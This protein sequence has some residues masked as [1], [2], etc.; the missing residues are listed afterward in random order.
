MPPYK[1]L[2]TFTYDKHETGLS[3]LESKYIFDGEDE[4]KLLWSNKQVDPSISAFI[5]QRLKVIVSNSDYPTLIQ[6]IKELDIHIEG[7]KVE[8]L[9]LEGDPTAYADRLTKL[10]DIGYRI[11]GNPDYYKPTII[12]TLCN[13]RGTW[14]FGSMTKDKFDWYKHGKKP[15]S[16]SNSIS[17]NIAKALVNIATGSAR[18]KTILDACCGVGTIMLEAC[19][20]GYDIEGC[21]INWKI[22]RNARVN[23]TH[24]GYETVVY[25]SD[26]KDIDKRYDAAIIDLPYNLLSQATDETTAHIIAS[27][28]RIAQR[29]VIVSIVDITEIIQNAG[30]RLL[31]TCGVGKRGKTGFERRVW[32]CESADFRAW[33]NGTGT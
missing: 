31:D 29:L 1:F 14:C 26:I 30:L 5:K 3:K 27:T 2:Y 12:Y 20:A 8:Y 28:A 11:E 6:E 21:D 16:Y 10:K 15:R 22:V 18:E 24:F 19:F 25:R 4:E 13:Y 17:P 33:L 23:L 9:V 7:F 32:V